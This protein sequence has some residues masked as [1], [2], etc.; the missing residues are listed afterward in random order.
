[1]KYLMCLIN[2][3]EVTMRN[4][5]FSQQLVAVQQLKMSLML[6]LLL[7]YTIVH[8]RNRAV[9]LNIGTAVITY[10]TLWGNSDIL[11]NP[12]F[13]MWYCLIRKWR[14]FLSSDEIHFA[15][16]YFA[17][18]LLLSLYFAQVVSCNIIFFHESIYCFYMHVFNT[19]INM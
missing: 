4:S 15:Y 11:Y 2:A 10:D 3:T 7:V 17:F 6:Y 9:I 12:T 13:V 1:M 14:S 18:I 8:T 19:F 5:I 16:C